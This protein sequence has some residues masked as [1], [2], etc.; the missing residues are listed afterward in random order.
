MMNA[1][2]GSLFNFL[3]F[4]HQSPNIAII[5]AYAIPLHIQLLVACL[6]G[7]EMIH[8]HAC[9]KELAPETQWNQKLCMLHLPLHLDCYVHLPRRLVSCAQTVLSH[10]SAWS[11]AMQHPAL[12]DFCS[13]GHQPF[14]TGRSPYSCKKKLDQL[15]HCVSRERCRFRQLQLP[16]GWFQPHP[17]SSE[18]LFGLNLADMSPLLSWHMS[19]HP[20]FGGND[21]WS[22]SSLYT[23]PRKRQYEHLWTM[24]NHLMNI[25]KLRVWYNKSRNFLA[26]KGSMHTA[27]TEGFNTFQC[28]M[29]WGPSHW[30]WLKQTS[31]FAHEMDFKC[32][33]HPF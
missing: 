2:L 32:H 33:L 5:Q 26:K 16:K 9:S 3:T 7:H 13:K 27:R 4:K 21:K 31:S 24:F 12:C 30:H 17:A 8:D 28:T 11:K 10:D 25:P 23:I 20:D 19:I 6:K 1:K 22:H 29:G 15:W 14:A 18:V